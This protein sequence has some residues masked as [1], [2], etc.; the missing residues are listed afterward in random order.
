MTEANGRPEAT[1]A[2]YEAVWKGWTIPGDLR[3]H[4]DRH[5]SDRAAL[6]RLL[7]RALAA[8]GIPRRALEIGC[9][10]AFDSVL[11]AERHPGF[12]V[13]ATDLSP[14]SVRV[15]GEIGQRLGSRVRYE[16]ADA[17]RM[18]YPDGWAGLV[19][20]QGVVE[21]FRDP[22]PLMREQARVTASGGFVLVDVPQTFNV[23]TL[24]KGVRI[25][26]GTWPWGWET[27]YSRFGL[28]RLAR[29]VGLVPVGWAGYGYWGGKF[30]PLAAVARLLPRAARA[31]LE[32][33]TG[34]WWLMNLAGL[35]RKP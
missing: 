28:A 8:P 25:R 32:A 15:A 35:F 23:Y 12:E 19:F 18:T 6:H 9:G 17:T 2:H 4:A 20:S 3:G 14:E 30:D 27:Q 31:R 10:T 26:Q 24:I 33:A 16:A 13:V 29:R 1:L 7:D 34:S 21:H 5:G 11:I 22:L